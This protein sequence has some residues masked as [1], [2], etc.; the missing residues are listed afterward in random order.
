MEYQDLEIKKN[1]HVAVVE[2]QRPPNNFFDT[3]LINDLADCFETFD[4]S[5]EVRAIVLCSQGKHFCA[6]NNFGNQQGNQERETRTEKRETRN[7]RRE[8]RNENGEKRNEKREKR[9][10]E[11]RAEKREARTEK[12]EKI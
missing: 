4:Q 5:H 10:R 2:I 12:R 11:Q 9:K 6:G 8:Q 1:K 7:E 3:Q